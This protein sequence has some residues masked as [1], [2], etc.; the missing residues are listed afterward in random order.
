M[1]EQQ[2]FTLE[3]ERARNLIQDYER[4]RKV[5]LE[6]IK[7]YLK[8]KNLNLLSS[9]C[10]NFS[11]NTKIK[12]ELEFYLENM[13]MSERTNSSGV[14]LKEVIIDPGTMLQFEAL[15]MAKHFSSLDLRQDMNISTDLH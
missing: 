6:L 15:V 11:Y 13:P 1:E 12:N 3:V 14:K 2:Y 9:L 5:V 4:H 7:H 8:E 10:E